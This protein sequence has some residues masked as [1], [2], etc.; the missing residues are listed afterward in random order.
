MQKQSFAGSGQ[1]QNRPAE[2]DPRHADAVTAE[3]IHHSHHPKEHA[4]HT[5]HEDDHHHRQPAQSDHDHEHEFNQHA[6]NGCEGHEHELD[7]QH[8]H[9]GHDRHGHH[10]SHL[11]Q[12]DIK[13]NGTTVVMH[14]QRPTGIQVKEAALKQGAPIE[15]TFV[16]Q[17]EHH[18]GTSTVGAD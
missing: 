10:H 5:K 15:L 16:L 2:S 18:D 12:A 11:F 3:Q 7:H 8:H 17:A 1:F 6:G 14:E 4:M 13:V 9:H